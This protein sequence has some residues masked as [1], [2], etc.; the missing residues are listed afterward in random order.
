MN[1]LVWYKKDLRLYDHEVLARAMVDGP[2]I[3][4]YVYEPEIYEA[5]DFDPSHMV[6]INQS[7]KE[8]HTKLKELGSGL[9]LLKGRVPDVFETLHR[10]ILFE[11]IWSHEETGNDITYKRDLRVAAWAEKQG[12]KWQEI[13][14]NGVVRRLKTRDGWS[15][16]WYARMAKHLFEEP[17]HINCPEAVKS[18]PGYGKVLTLK[19]LGLP[20]STISDAQPGG[21]ECAQSM[22]QSF[23]DERGMYYRKAMSSP[24]TAESSCSRLSPHITFGN[25]SMKQISQAAKQRS[26]EIKSLS[27]PKEERSAWLGSLQSFQGRLRWHCHFMQKLEDEPR[28]EFENMSKVY[29]GLRESEFNEDY[30]DA[31]CNGMT[32]YP[33]V[34]AC[35]RALHKTGWINFRMRAMLVSFASYHLWLHW[36]R[37]ALFLARKFLD[38][39]PGIHYSQFQMQSGVTGIN[40]IRIYSPSKQVLDHD[41]EGDFIKR[42]VPE[43]E[44]VP[45]EFLAN[46]EKMTEMH[47]SLFGVNLGK[48]YPEPIVDHKVAVKEA[49]DKVWAVRKQSNAKTEA[50]KIL[51]KHGSRRRPRS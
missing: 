19:K 2:V 29:D 14:Q 50:A 9:I 44:A 35:M 37:P 25:I 3:Q 45:S 32:G 5:E 36:R 1:Q 51:K 24:V 11:K 22:L 28:I 7:L 27:L 42:Y 10:K 12:V 15:K 38:F 33:M 43:L 6:F 23:L 39:E 49:R 13:T 31:W 46:P 47:Q 30:F 21:E 41:P 34:D 18:H 20:N 48:D 16:N 8:L 40:T 26:E 4:V 17:E